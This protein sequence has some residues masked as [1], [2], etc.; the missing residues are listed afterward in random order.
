M[1]DPDVRTVAKVFIVDD[2][3]PVRRSLSRL[4]RSAGY[5]VVAVSSAADYINTPHEG[6]G[7]LILDV[8]MP[9]MTGPELQDRLTEIGS[10]LPIVFLTGQGDVATGIKAMKKGAFDFLTKPVDESDLLTAVQGALEAHESVRSQKSR[11]ES[12]QARVETLTPREQDIMRC[13]ISGALNKQIATHL[14]IAE[15]T[16]KVHRARVLEKMEVLSLA[17]L[18]RLCDLIGI[19]PGCVRT[20]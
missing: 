11:L 12:I 1:A 7:C 6:I 3:E 5:Q 14:S 4:L 2:D 18:A 9:D 13:M 19:E 15:K 20:T 8:R 16:V 17:E 10:D